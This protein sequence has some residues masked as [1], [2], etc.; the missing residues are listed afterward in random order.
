MLLVLVAFE[1]VFAL[2]E[3]FSSGQTSRIPALF[4]RYFLFALTLVICFLP[5]LVSKKIIYGSFFESGYIPIGLWNWKSPSFFQV[6]FSANHGLFSWTPLLLFAVLGIIA[7]WRKSVKV[8]GAALCAVLAFYYVIASYPDWDGISSFGNRFFVSLTGFFVVGLAFFLQRVADFFRPRRFSTTMASLFLTSFVL[9]NLGL[10]FQWGSHLIPAR[11]PVS[12]G[13]VA[14]NQFA[15]VPVELMGQLRAYFFRRKEL[16]HS[17]EQR[18]VQ[19]L[20]Q[21]SSH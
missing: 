6:L 18:D 10:M 12:W 2:R 17:I 21:Q 15:V 7:F 19:Q 14:H 16:M 4:A 20:K 13:Q 5:T 11:G 1:I 3:V 9:W 8:G